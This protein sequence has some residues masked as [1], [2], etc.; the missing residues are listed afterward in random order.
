MLT[1]GEGRALRLTLRS[2]AAPLPLDSLNM[3]VQLCVQGNALMCSALAYLRVCVCL[4][5]LNTSV[6]SADLC[7]NVVFFACTSASP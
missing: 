7:T 4:C 1:E 6:G 5:V 2:G 3:H